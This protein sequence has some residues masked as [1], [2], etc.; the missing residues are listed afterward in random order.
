MNPARRARPAH[1]LIGDLIQAH[2]QRWTDAYQQNALS[3]LNRYAHWIAARG[4]DLLE[5][6][7]ADLNDYLDSRRTTGV[8]GSTLVKDHQFLA[9]LYRWLHTE[10]EL[11]GRNPM[12]RVARP[13][14][15]DRVDP[16]RIGYVTDL[17]YRRLLDS[18]DMRLTLDCRNAAIASRSPVTGISL[19]HAEK[20]IPRAWTYASERHVLWVSHG[21]PGPRHRQGCPL[22]PH[23]QVVLRCSHP[24]T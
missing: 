7:S 11:P 17:E 10:S 9:H 19:P 12:G 3:I 22:A 8:S 5:V 2:R 24:P 16:A 21:E 20:L 4:V 15:A 18:F 14:G 6:S 23:S 1:P 13:K